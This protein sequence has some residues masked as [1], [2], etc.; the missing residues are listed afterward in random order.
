MSEATIVQ[1]HKKPGD[2]FLTGENLYSFETEKALQD[3][4]ST[5]RG[6]MLEILVPE[7][8]NAQVGEVVC[9]VDMELGK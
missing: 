5:G 3:V 4:E 8:A 2:A 6:K 9:I 1:W 7:G